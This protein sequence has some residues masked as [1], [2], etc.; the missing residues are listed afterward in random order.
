MYSVI[1]A[2][3]KLSGGGVMQMMS[4]SPLMIFALAFS[5]IIAIAMSL[6]FARIAHGCRYDRPQLYIVLV[7]VL[8]AMWTSRD[9]RMANLAQL[10][11]LSVIIAVAI[12]S[13]GLTNAW[14]MAST[15]CLLPTSFP[16]SA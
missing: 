13:G 1:Q 10:I 4:L 7:A 12:R 11:V 5:L 15:Q 3:H 8:L 9:P 6:L 16:A 2:R 14:N